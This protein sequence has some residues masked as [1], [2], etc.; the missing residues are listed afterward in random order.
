MEEKEFLT[1]A[2]K[3][4][5]LY[6]EKG[7]KFIS[8]VYPVTDPAQIEEHLGSLKKIHPGAT[9]HCYAYILGLN[10]EKY[11]SFDNGEPKHS[12]GEPIMGQ[13]RSRGLTN[14][15]VVVVRYFGGKKLGVGGL[16]RAYQAAASDALDNNKIISRKVTSKLNLIFPY[17]ATSQV[18]GIL[19]EYG[20]QII[21]QQFNQHCEAILEVPESI[22]QSFKERMQAIGLDVRTLS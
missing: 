13:I 19:K 3:S 16:V 4:Q 8:Y 11:R 6:K 15:L 18:T 21:S 12:A 20:I 5:G 14:L 7:S 2:S 10:Q 17:Q 1:L 9:H 22:Q